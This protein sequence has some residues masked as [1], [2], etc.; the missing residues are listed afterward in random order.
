MVVDYDGR[1]LAQA[2]PGPGEK[3]VVAPIDVGALRAERKRRIGHDLRAHL[4]S[5]LYTYLDRQ[6]LAPGGS[7]PPSIEGLRQRIAEAK[8]R[9]GS[10]PE[11]SA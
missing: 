3:I 2:D 4:R 6:R 5:E 8:G 1:I 7:G 11:D 10:D 9:A